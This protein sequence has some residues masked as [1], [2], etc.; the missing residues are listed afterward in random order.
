MNISKWFFVNFKSNLRNFNYLK[1]IPFCTWSD[2][3][4][5]NYDLIAKILEKIDLDKKLLVSIGQTQAPYGITINPDNDKVLGQLLNSCQYS[6][7]FTS[8]SDE[9]DYLLKTVLCGV[10]PICNLNH[11]FISK[12]GLKSFATL[13]DLENLVDKLVEIKYNQHIFKHRVSLLSWNYG[14]Q[15]KKWNKN[16]NV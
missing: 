16:K 14:Q 11:V 5:T 9:T 13:M 8:R 1:Q 3:K 12:L 2:I 15:L 10:I 7:V 4:S 6:F